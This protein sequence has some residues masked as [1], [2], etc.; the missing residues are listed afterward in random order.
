MNFQEL[1]KTKFRT[2]RE[3]AA[4]LGVNTPRVQKWEGG[5][6]I[7]T[8]YLRPVAKLLGVSVNTLLDSIER[9]RK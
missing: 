7:P 8:A 5:S 9:G 3:F 4:A 1:R 6:N 2:A